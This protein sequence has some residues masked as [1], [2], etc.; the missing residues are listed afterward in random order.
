M[1]MRLAK[2]ELP[3]DV[4]TVAVVDPIFL[5]ALL[6]VRI[7]ELLGANCRGR[8]Q[9]QKML[10]LFECMNDV[11]LDTQFLRKKF[12]PFDSDLDKIEAFIEQKQWLQV[13]P[14]NATQ[15]KKL[16]NY[17]SYRSEFEKYWECYTDEID[18]LIHFFATMKTSQAE[19]FATLMAVWNDFILDGKNTPTDAELIEEVTTNWHPHKANF[20]PETWLDTLDKM[21]TNN[22]VPHGYGKH[23]IKITGGNEE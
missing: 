11:K 22:I 10:Y 4:E 17:Q 19:R 8:I 15:Y 14:G 13:V 7:Q 1:S 23:T 21:R 20:K 9:I 6:Y 3:S 18:R 12:G 16:G 5:K 2:K